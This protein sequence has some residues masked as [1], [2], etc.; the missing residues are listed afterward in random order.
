MSPKY[1][2]CSA[3]DSGNYAVEYQNL[4]DVRGV[5]HAWQAQTENFYSNSMDMMAPAPLG[6]EKK[7]KKEKEERRINSLNQIEL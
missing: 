3:S 6:K 1:I 4:S 7:E 2:H 5:F